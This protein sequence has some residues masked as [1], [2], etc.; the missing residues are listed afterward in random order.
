[1]NRIVA[2][3]LS[4]WHFAP[5]TRARDNLLAEGVDP[6]AIN[7]TGNTVIDAL[8]HV[9]RR[10]Y[11]L[12]VDIPADKRLVL[13]T[14]HRRENFGAPFCQVCEGILEL[15]DRHPAIHLLYPVHP[16]P[17][18]RIQAREMRGLQP[19][20]TLCEQLESLALVAALKSPTLH[21]TASKR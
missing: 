17:N 21:P 9:A 15:V 19:A 14:A 6:A 2:G 13:V 16:T 10:D 5:T 18:G 11:P 8:E 4:R 3:R 12:P 7:V 1:M 20:I